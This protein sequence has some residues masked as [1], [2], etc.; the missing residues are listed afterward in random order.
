MT[1][2]DVDLAKQ[3]F[4]SHPANVVEE[5]A[6]QAIGADEHYRGRVFH[7][8]SPLHAIDAQRSGIADGV[9]HEPP[10]RDDDHDHAGVIETS[11]CG[12]EQ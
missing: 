5:A 12:E 1:L 2:I 6:G 8:V 4:R 9:V 3:P 11:G 7:P 10:V